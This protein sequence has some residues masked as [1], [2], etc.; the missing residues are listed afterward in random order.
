MSRFGVIVK[1]IPSNTFAH[2]FLGLMARPDPVNQSRSRSHAI[3]SR[4]CTYEKTPFFQGSDAARAQ[5][6][7]SLMSLFDRKKLQMM[8]INAAM[9]EHRSEGIPS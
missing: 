5:S 6:F 7:L 8:T 9:G 1:I 3:G 2:F 4:L